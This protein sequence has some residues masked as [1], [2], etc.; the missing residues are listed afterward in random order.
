MKK[1]ISL[2]LVFLLTCVFCVPAF[3]LVSENA[4]DKDYGRYVDP[5]DRQFAV[6]VS[7]DIESDFDALKKEYSPA[8]FGNE[9]IARILTVYRSDA[10]YPEYYEGLLL[11][12]AVSGYAS[13]IYL[14]P[15]DTS[16]AGA[17]KLYSRIANV[18]TRRYLQ[19]E[20]GEPL[21]GEILTGLLIGQADL[22]SFT[23]EED[24]VF[25]TYC[26]LVG[27]WREIEE[28]ALS[29]ADFG[30]NDTDVVSIV[31]TYPGGHF[32]S[33][34]YDGYYIY[35][36]DN[37]KENAEALARTVGQVK[38]VAAVSSEMEFFADASILEANLVMAGIKKGAPQKVYSPADFDDALVQHLELYAY[39]NGEKLA[40]LYL[41]EPNAENA[42]ALC[43][44][45]KEKDFVKYAEPNG[46]IQMTEY[47]VGD[48]DM[49]GKITSADA[50]LVLRY[51]VGLE[52]P[53][54]IYSKFVS[55]C[56]FD[57]SITSADARTVLRTAVGL[58]DVQRVS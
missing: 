55:D 2:L 53:E 13:Y 9:G 16:R 23:P 28:R 32:E 43:D 19:K 33:D 29:A 49:D 3:A 36:R 57:G 51:A 45:L 54:F 50:R 44:V 5:G 18:R 27:V 4:W 38:R 58:E 25:D 31:S 17:L 30:L 15:E 46:L 20:N 7:I 14:I 39:E 40:F 34:F 48:A 22:V 21:T 52:A 35:L 8:D 10:Y 47:T 37:T 1:S 41:K 42:Q 12:K 26:L 56:D 24:F 6:A 11:E